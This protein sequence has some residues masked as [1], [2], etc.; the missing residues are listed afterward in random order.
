MMVVT[1]NTKLKVQPVVMS[2]HGLGNGTNKKGESHDMT[3][4]VVI[5]FDPP[6]S[7]YIHLHHAQINETWYIIYAI[8]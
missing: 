1:P 6:P 3:Q 7:L 8:W 4:H 5:D 2:I